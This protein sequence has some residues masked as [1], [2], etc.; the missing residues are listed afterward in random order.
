MEPSTKR[1]KLTQTVLSLNSKPGFVQWVHQLSDYF[2]YVI[3]FCA[4]D[5]LPRPR[6]YHLQRL[7]HLDTAPCASQTGKGCI[8]AP[9]PCC[10]RYP[11]PSPRWNFCWTAVNLQSLRQWRHWRIRTAEKQLNLL[12]SSSLPAHLLECY[13]WEQLQLSLLTVPSHPSLTRL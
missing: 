2:V 7:G 11:D 8:G 13:C 12:K 3:S 6:T 9:S 4:I 5:P 10:E 1:L